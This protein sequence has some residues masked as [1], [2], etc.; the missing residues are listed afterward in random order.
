MAEAN[1]SGWTRRD[2]LRTSGAGALTLG[3][4]NLGYAWGS[5]EQPAVS[6]STSSA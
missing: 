1:R 6:R 2:F 3:F 5:P 4:V